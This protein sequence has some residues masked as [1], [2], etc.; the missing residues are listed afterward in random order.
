[1]SDRTTR[2]AVF[3]VAAAGAG[4]ASYLTYVHYRPDAL[5]CT[6]SG[7]CETVQDS[8]Y[9]TLAGVPIALLG[10][11]AYMAVIVL[12]AIDSRPARLATAVI[13]L[14]GLAFALYLVVLQA[15][16][17]DAWCVWCLAND[18]LV[19]PL[20]AALAVLRCREPVPG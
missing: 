4:I 18:V 7:G 3:V 5:V 9:A 11:A 8:E 2:V 6:G 16:V 20:L 19:L 15:F 14:S 17:I 10:L 13:A 1:V 12:T